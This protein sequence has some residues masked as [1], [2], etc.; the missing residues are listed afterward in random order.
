MG[1]FFSKTG[2]VQAK[3]KYPHRPKISPGSIPVSSINYAHINIYL[4]GRSFHEMVVVCFKTELRASRTRMQKNWK[5]SMFF[6]I[7]ADHP[8]VLIR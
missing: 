8:N 2:S 7:F 5:F 6:S 1:E 3:Q 4:L